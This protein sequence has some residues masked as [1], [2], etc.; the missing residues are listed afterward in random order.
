MHVYHND[1]LV[2][3]RR[4]KERQFCKDMIALSTTWIQ[5]MLTECNKMV[6]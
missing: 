3:G 1:D 5:A 2:Q 4:K 6:E